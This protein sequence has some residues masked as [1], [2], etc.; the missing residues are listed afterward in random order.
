M[1]TTS[2]QQIQDRLTW[3]QYFMEV[4]RL[5][6]K[7][8]S[9]LRRQVGAVLVKD[10]MIISTG[11]NGAPKGIE[12]CLQTRK[13]IRQEFNVPSGERIELCKA[14]HAEQNAIVQAAVNG[15]S[16]K[17]SILYCTYIPC[18]TC[19]KLLINSEISQI[20]YDE[21][22][23]DIE[24]LSLLRQAKIAINRIDK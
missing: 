9:C 3:N 15:I 6:A 18:I 16:T 11:Y 8:S 5:I 21:D 17:G 1:S 10:N 13:C 22:Y 4:A 12:S 19:T 14:V 2:M 24:G 20:Y 23:R 7:R